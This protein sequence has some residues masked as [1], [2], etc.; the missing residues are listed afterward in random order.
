MRI[1]SQILILLVL[2]LTGCAATGPLFTA[3][4]ALEPSTSE[5]VVYRPDAFARGGVTYRV[6]LDEKHVANLQNAG[7]AV[8]STEP[9]THELEISAS[10][11]QNFKPLKASVKTVSG[12]RNYFRFSPHVSGSTVVTPIIVYIPVGYGFEE[13]METTAFEELKSLRLSE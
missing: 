5:I 13:V 2:Q 6:S 3:R 12:G 8:F 7:Y 11:F 10:V 1:K 9:G 4:P